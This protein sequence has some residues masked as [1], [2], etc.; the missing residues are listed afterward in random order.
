MKSFFGYIRVSTVK[1]GQQGVSLQEQRDS[2]LRYASRN[3][4]EIISWFEEQE[5]AA[6][7]GRP[8][9]NK[10]LKLLHQGKAKGVVLHKIDR[11]ARNLKD[12]ADMADLSDAGIEVHFA[13]ESIDLH[14][15]GGRLSADIQAVVAADYI[16][17]LREETKKGFYGR[18]KQGLYPLPAPIGYLDRGKGKP[19][20]PD[21]MTAP[22]V[23]K[24]FELYGTSRFSFDRL[25]SE[26]H[27]LGLRNKHGRM[28]TRNGLWLILRN[29]F[30]IGI[31]RL[32]RTGETFPGAH[33]PLVSKSLF[34]RVRLIATSK[35]HTRV[36]CH[37]FLFRRLLTCKHCGHTLIGEYQKGHRYY[38]CHTSGCLTKCVREELV[39][40]EILHQLAPLRF[41]ETERTCF[42]H[43]LS[44]LKLDWGKQQ[45]E[46]LKTLHLSL[47]QLRDRLNR[48]T[49]A[50][51]DSSIDRAT[52]EQRKMALLLEQKAVEENMAN[53]RADTKP[54]PDRALEFLEL[55]GSVWLS[56]QMGITE[57]RRD[58]LKTVTSNREVDGKNVVVKLSN[59]F[60][61][62]ANRPPV[63]TGDPQ[64]DIPRI[65]DTLLEKL[66][67]WFAE[68]PTAQFGA[69]RI[70]DGQDLIPD[71]PGLCTQA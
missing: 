57:E 49:D 14:S 66:S 36:Q 61:E 2:I 21:P 38:R 40:S 28:V 17:N 54:L 55:A 39:E 42:R 6:K 59:P 51:L 62:V 11:G 69:A 3:S 60:F 1:Q 30:Y 15:R 63:T 46:E 58:L 32:S 34:D 13:N 44:E 24:A 7:R 65:W 19:K 52:F 26:L 22:L 16:R 29:P 5:T 9:F 56:Y 43:K 27:R 47:G 41:D 20:E 48:L 31:I 50:F 67:K 64:R 10:M 45:E 12:W 71:P 53:L 68:N 33:P 18:I 70:G 8:V 35:G 23:Q 37:D 25:V 4:F